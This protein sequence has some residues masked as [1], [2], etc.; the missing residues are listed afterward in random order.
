MYVEEKTGGN[1]TIKRGEYEEYVKKIKIKKDQIGP[2]CNKIA[3]E[4]K[5]AQR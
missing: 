4:L 3:K 5:G 1:K 2:R